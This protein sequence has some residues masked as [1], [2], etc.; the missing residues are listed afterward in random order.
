M[1]RNKIDIDEVLESEFKLEY[2]MRILAYVKPFKKTIVLIVILLMLTGIANIVNPEIVKITIDKFIPNK[3]IDFILLAA[4]ALTATTLLTSLITKYKITAMNNVGQSAI[5]ALRKDVFS[6]LQ[7]LPFSYFDNR[8]H[9]KILVRVVHYVNSISDLLSNGLV[10]IITDLFNVLVLVAVMLAVNWRLALVAMSPFP[11]FVV[12]IVLMKTSLHRAWQ[13]YSAKNSNLTAYIQESISGMKVTQAYSREN[14]NQGIFHDMIMDASE[15]WMKAQK[16]AQ[17]IG[18]MVDL[19][20]I[21]A[22]LLLYI[23]G[24]RNFDNGITIGMLTQFTIYVAMFW[25]PVVNLSNQ[26][27][28]LTTASAYMESI[29]D[30]LDEKPNVKDADDAVDMPVINGDIEFRNVCFAYEPKQMILNNVNFNVKQG[31]TIALVGPTGAGKTT[32]INLL[33]RFY[34]LTDGTIFIDGI[35]ISKVTLKSL[36]RQMGVMLQDTFIFSGTIA[37]NIRYSK[38]DATEQEIIDAAKTVCADEFI[39]SMENGYDTQVNE[40]G[41]RLSAGQRQLISFARALLAD[42]KILI[43]D[44]ATSSIDTETEMALQKGLDRLLSGRTS[45][46]IAH[47]LSTIKNADRIMYIDKGRIIE[48]GSHDE[49]MKKQGAYYRLYTAQY[50]FLDE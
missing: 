23:Y 13:N 18:P 8:P 43:L 7:T 46:V 28:A 36:R 2:L 14:C 39:Q 27:N 11:V 45:F 1:A 6:H 21:A 26:Y 9:G 31:E 29:F 5:A 25:N 37:D 17:A 33:S 48:S 34:N 30:L 15:K 38:L 20:S 49:L 41:S 12:I 35:D 50:A 44:E 19:A 42:P 22:T 16:I 24:I 3:R 47:R 32:I 10:N 40:R 4:F